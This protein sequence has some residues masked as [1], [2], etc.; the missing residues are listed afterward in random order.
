MLQI[1]KCGRERPHDSETPPSER[2][3]SVRGVIYKPYAGTA[4]PTRGVRDKAHPKYKCKE[5]EESK[6]AVAPAEPA[7]RPVPQ[8]GPLGSLRHT[9][10]P[11]SSRRSRPALP[12][13][14]RMREAGMAGMA[15]AAPALRRYLLLL[16]QEHLEFRLPVS[17]ARER[18]WHW[19][20]GRVRRCPPLAA[21]PGRCRT[22]RPPGCA[23]A[24]GPGGVPSLRESRGRSAQHPSPRRV[25]WEGTPRRAAASP[26]CPR[27][28]ES[29]CAVA[30]RQ[31]FPSARFSTASGARRGCQQSAR[32]SAWE[33]E[34]GV[35]RRRSGFWRWWLLKFVWVIR[36]LPP[37]AGVAVLAWAQPGP[38]HGLPAAGAATG[39]AGL[40][41]R[42]CMCRSVPGCFT[43]SCSL[44]QSTTMLHVTKCLMCLESFIFFGFVE[45]FF[46]V[47]LFPVCFEL[48]PEFRLWST[49]FFFRQ[50][51]PMK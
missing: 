34:A 16:A 41:E 35:A 18:G 19:E 8:P 23:G 28:M 9:P 43:A 12:C 11:S 29:L 33:A 3:P 4:A 1:L 48:E 20:R 6:W 27:R 49:R 30:L 21:P 25:P 32:G 38:L 36:Q 45:V 46:C 50:G 2:V 22:A 42:D 39:P 40:R 5:D 24:A 44:L 13:R 51:H 17:A 31:R 7:Q 47:L 15:L 37:G 10:L 14:R 26:P